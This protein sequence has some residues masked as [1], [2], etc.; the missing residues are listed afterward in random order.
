M[1][2]KEALALIFKSV[3]PVLEENGFEP[4]Y[5]L[6]VRKNEAPIEEQSDKLRISF[7]GGQGAVRIEYKEARIFLLCTDINAS[8]ATDEDYKQASLSLFDPSTGADKDI[9][10]VGNEFSDTIRQKFGKKERNAAA[11]DVYKRQADARFQIGGQKRR[12][13]L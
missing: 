12:T 5:P 4:V 1:E 6:D 2:I 11:S 7:Q 3:A 10:Y 13:C 8:E 9:R